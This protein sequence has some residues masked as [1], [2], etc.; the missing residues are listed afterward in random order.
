MADRNNNNGGKARQEQGNNHR[1]GNGGNNN[2]G[3]S[4]NKNHN[5]SGNKNHN[6]G[7]KNHFGNDKKHH[8]DKH[9]GKP[10]NQ[11]KP[12][13]HG[14]GYQ[15]HPGGGHDAFRPGVGQYHG[16]PVPPPPP[17]PVMRPGSGVAFHPGPAMPPPPPPRLPH[18]VNYA[19][20]GCQD[21]AVW[22]VDPETFLVR[23]RRG[24]RWYTRYVYPYAE[25]YGAP[26]LISVNWQP[27][28]PWTLIPPI[29]LNINL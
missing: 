22:Q 6:G 25:R 9:Y 29:Q 8:N 4:G 16:A 26:T 20:R 21:V 15:G 19:T 23:Y 28:A 10:G 12:G 27:S 24:G 11:G 13:N 3:N 1:P 17:A 2:R 7:N 14:N 5:S 18:M